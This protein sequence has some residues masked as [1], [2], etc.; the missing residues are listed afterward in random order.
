MD[1]QQTSL[2]EYIS[3]HKDVIEIIGV[4]TTVAAALGEFVKDAKAVRYISCIFIILVFLLLWE[5]YKTFPPRRTTRVELFFVFFCF[6]VGAVILAVIVNNIDFLGY[7]AAG[8]ILGT[9]IALISMA[10]K[11]LSRWRK[12]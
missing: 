12:R 5:L 9:I 4:F 10:P 11:L 7:L 2:A 3:Q 6:G 1:H 8:G